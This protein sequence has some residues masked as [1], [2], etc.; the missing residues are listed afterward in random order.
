METVLTMVK[1]NQLAMGKWMYLIKGC[2][3]YKYFLLNYDVIISGLNE[4][5]ILAKIVSKLT[6]SNINKLSHYYP[7]MII[8]R[9]D[10]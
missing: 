1:E 9:L 3:S 2:T 5:E 7:T 4:S 8:C 6:F 10:C